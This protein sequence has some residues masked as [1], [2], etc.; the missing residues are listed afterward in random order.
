MVR[1]WFEAE[2]R[3]RSIAL[4][5]S[6]HAEAMTVS[7]SIQAE[8]IANG[9]VPT[10]QV[11]TGH[12]GQAIFVGDIVQTRR[13]DGLAGV[14]NRESWVVKSI[15]NGAVLLA[16]P[17]DASDLRRITASYAESHL[18]L[19]YATTVYGVQGETTDLSIVG[20][21]VDAAGLYVGLTRGKES[22]RAIVVSTSEASARVELAESM[23]RHNIEPTVEASRSAALAELR[24]SARG[25][26][27]PEMSAPTYAVQSI[28]MG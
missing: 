17:G 20:P 13:N 27:A 15:T 18:H 10:E 6:T 28:D 7:E 5:T 3:G 25:S 9:T 16:A 19:A 2:R 11:A 14:Q 21:G 8:R 1:E 4:V 12:A 24:R 23:S 26:T 22:N